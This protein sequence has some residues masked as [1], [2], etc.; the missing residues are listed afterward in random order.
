MVNSALSAWSVTHSSRE[1]TAW[2]GRKP[3]SHKACRNAEMFSRGG[4]LLSDSTSNR[5]STSEHGNSSRRPNPPTA[6]S[7]KPVRKD[8][9]SVRAYAA[10]TS[11]STSAVRP[12]S[13]C[14]T[15]SGLGGGSTA[16][17]FTM[18]PSQYCLHNTAFPI[19]PSQC[20]FSSIVVADPN[21]VRYVVHKNFSV[22]DLARA[23]RSG[24]GPDDFIGALIRHYHFQLHLRQQVHAVFHPAVDLGMTFL[25]AVS[26]HFGDGHAV[27]A[28]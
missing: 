23:R 17:C 25:P 27:D 19:L 13:F 22:S 28:D 7:V 26:A 14:W 3:E 10:S 5:R 16:S 6:A 12:D 11:S 2:L 8:G 15:S 1:C 4:T 21:R 20:C 18:L 9:W 24:Q